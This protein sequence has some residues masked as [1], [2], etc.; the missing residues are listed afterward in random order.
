MK[1]KLEQVFI[2]MYGL[3]LISST[4]YSEIWK[5]DDLLMTWDGTNGVRKVKIVCDN[6]DKQ[7]FK[8]CQ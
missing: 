2:D 8:N 6:T 7:H 3:L 1:A 4:Q 5:V